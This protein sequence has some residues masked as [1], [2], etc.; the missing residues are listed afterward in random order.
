MSWMNPQGTVPLRAQG[1]YF[2][3]YKFQHQQLPKRSVVVT[4]Q[5]EQ[6]ISLCSGSIRKRTGKGGHQVVLKAEL[7]LVF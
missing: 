2:L 5:R 1:S 3:D 7:L 4:D 6:F